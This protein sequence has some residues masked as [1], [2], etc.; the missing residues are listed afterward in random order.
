MAN[1]KIT[2]V[3]WSDELYAR[4]EA[5]AQK[6]ELPVAS[7]IRMVVKEHLDAQ[8]KGERGRKR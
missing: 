1:T 3:R 4:L 8:E 6:K 7:Y 5:E 2:S